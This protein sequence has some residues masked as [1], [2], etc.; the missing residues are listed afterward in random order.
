M[1]EERRSETM[2]ALISCGLLVLMG[3]AANLGWIR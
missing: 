2:W 3:V 1:T